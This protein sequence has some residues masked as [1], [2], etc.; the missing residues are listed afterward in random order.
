MTLKKKTFFLDNTCVSNSEN[1]DDV[2]VTRDPIPVIF[3]RIAKG[4]YIISIKRKYLH[5]S[6]QMRVV[7]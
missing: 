2:L 7:F 6:F 3:N 5:L 1:N 4:K